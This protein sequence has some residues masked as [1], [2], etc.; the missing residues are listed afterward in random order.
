M[1]QQAERYREINKAQG[2]PAASHMPQ[3]GMFTDL[4]YVN[5]CVSC[6]LGEFCAVDRP[7]HLAPNYLEFQPWFCMQELV[8]DKLNP[9]IQ[10]D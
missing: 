2:L 9:L 5:A 1:I 10:G 7:A 3:E 8:K 4:E 6:E